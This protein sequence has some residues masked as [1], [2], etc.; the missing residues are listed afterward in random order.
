MLPTY[1]GDAA[2]C[3]TITPGSTATTLTFNGQSVEFW[4]GSPTASQ[5]GP[6]VLYWHGTGESAANVST[7][8]GSAGITAV[9]G[10][11]GVVAA[12]STSTAS[13]TSTGNN[14]WYTGDFVTADEVV[15]CAIAE[16]K[17]DTRRI[18]VMGDSAGGLETV[19]MS[20]S[21]SGYIASVATLSGGVTGLQPTTYQDP[22]NVPPAL[23]VHGKAGSDVVGIDFAIA[24]A[25]WEADI[26][27]AGGFS[28]DCNT[29]GGH[30]SGPPAIDP[31]IWQFFV[32]HPFRVSPQPYPPIPSVFPTYCVIGPRSADGGP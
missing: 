8:L 15:A 1:P 31:G 3:P 24:S 7:Y 21:R 20:Y 27:A 17:I 9:T 5:H 6:L 29:G 2:A 26:R 30:V 11:G 4:V 18:Y 12:F 19:W 22:T 25:S 16:L 10:A 13:G 14:V 23:V 28:M 32:D